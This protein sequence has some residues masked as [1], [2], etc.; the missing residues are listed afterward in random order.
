MLKNSRIWKT[1]RVAIPLLALLAAALL[2]TG[3][4]CGGDEPAATATPEFS[5]P[6]ALP[7]PEAAP[8]P[9]AGSEAT[10]ATVASAV[11]GTQDLGTPGREHPGTGNPGTGGS[12]FFP[13]ARAGVRRRSAGG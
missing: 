9:G 3:V 4:A 1:P 11:A 12:A 2:V 7:S 10:A 6:T 5:L 13:G 8:A